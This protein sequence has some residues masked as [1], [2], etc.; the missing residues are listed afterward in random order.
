MSWAHAADPSSRQ[1]VQ[2]TRRT[3]TP[4]SVD[5]S[6]FV[7]VRLLAS[8]LCK[9]GV[10]SG[11][12]SFPGETLWEVPKTLVLQRFWEF[13]EVGKNPF[14]FGQILLQ[15]YLNVKIKIVQRGILKFRRLG[16]KPDIPVR[17]LE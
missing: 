15:V 5:A 14:R 3:R 4:V 11:K 16:G 9:D 13:G 12:D 8:G 6:V 1:G 17:T 2:G 7:C 10:V